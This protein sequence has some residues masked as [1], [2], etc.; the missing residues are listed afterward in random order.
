MQHA[1]NASAV[2]CR[3][4]QVC[5][6]LAQCKPP[7]RYLQVRLPC[8]GRE[9]GIVHASG[10]SRIHSLHSST[11]APSGSKNAAAGFFDAAAHPSL[12]QDAP[13]IFIEWHHAV[14]HADM[15]TLHRL[16][17]SLEKEIGRS[18]GRLERIDG[19]TIRFSLTSAFDV[20]ASSLSRNPQQWVPAL[21][22]LLFAK[23]GSLLEKFGTIL[24]TVQVKLIARCL[25]KG[26]ADPGFVGGQ[27][28]DQ[29]VALL[30]RP[31]CQLDIEDGS[32]LLNRLIRKGRLELASRVIEHNLRGACE[33]SPSQRVGL[34]CLFS[35]LAWCRGDTLQ[36]SRHLGVSTSSATLASTSTPGLSQA[37]LQLHP[38]QHHLA[39]ARA[40]ANELKGR[41]VTEEGLDGLLRHIAAVESPSAAV[42]Y[43]VGVES[44]SVPVNDPST[45]MTL[46]SLQALIEGVVW[47]FEDAF[48]L[49]A[50]VESLTRLP[51]PPQAWEFCV[52]ALVQSPDERAGGDVSSAAQVSPA[53]RAEAELL[54]QKCA[55]QGI[56][57]PISAA[58]QVIL[59]HRKSFI[60]D[61]GSAFSI[62]DQLLNRHDEA[63]LSRQGGY[64]IYLDLL[65]ICVATA[66]VDRA[67]ALLGNMNTSAV[68]VLPE[69][70]VPIA[71][72]LALQADREEQVVQITS[73]ALNVC[74]R[75][76][77]GHLPPNEIQN[78][79]K[80][81]LR[82]RFNATTGHGRPQ[83]L[84]RDA[85]ISVFSAL[86]KAR[87]LPSAAEYTDLL[88]EII[89]RCS[90][91]MSAAERD[92]LKEHVITI[93]E[94]LQADLDLEP[95][96]GLL[97]T[98]MNAYNHLGHVDAALDIWHSLQAGSAPIDGA[99]LAIVFDLCAWARLPMEARRAYAW[100]Q[101]LDARSMQ[102]AT[103]TSSRPLPLV[104]NPNALLSYHE[105]LC[106]LWRLR[107]SI[108]LAWTRVEQGAF[109]GSAKSR[110]PRQWDQ[111]QQQQCDAVEKVAV[112]HEEVRLF[113]VLL[114][115]AARE[116]DRAN[117]P[118]DVKDQWEILR[119]RLRTERPEV[120][121]HVKTVGMAR[122]PK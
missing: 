114:K 73:R 102:G 104:L 18:I 98:L 29:A 61:V 36:A 115:F 118:E 119:Q 24:S 30:A 39:L 86:A 121:E 92:N 45:F 9:Q 4:A 89:S 110:T 96:I 69:H 67:I 77:L 42:S 83:G 43:F 12:S 81:L 33:L 34:D 59:A 87:G 40:I 11:R 19:K 10:S 58:G 52:C 84:S 75:T 90:P 78:Y 17:P 122:R 25:A 85:L 105:F 21:D 70:L 63:Q 22:A 28:L 100:A 20:V 2:R 88:G 62:Y 38:A 5:L 94:V 50:K 108:A 56:N 76:A 82:R 8:F 117:A 54:L 26:D 41:P 64:S 3:P 111:Q 1:M 74:K 31:G 46:L 97:N 91:S 71:T 65:E 27:L 72:K 51:A 80:T 55:Q 95:D 7:T 15:D 79:I 53:S 35:H 49:V 6:A 23:V 37:L 60:P 116:R 99:T 48:Q 103:K 14:Q 13:P 107:E 109:E 106:R 47:S 93:H 112:D 120:W 113:R 101:S 68:I 57:V 32:F 44:S 16:L 66:S